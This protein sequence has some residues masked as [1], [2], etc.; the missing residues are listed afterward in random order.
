MKWTHFF[1]LVAIA[2]LLATPMSPFAVL[3]LFALWAK[4]LG[5]LLL[6]I[7][8]IFK[9]GVCSK[10]K[11]PLASFEKEES[12]SKNQEKPNVDLAQSLVIWEPL[13]FKV[14][15]SRNTP[16]TLTFTRTGNNMTATCTCPAGK[17]L[18]QCKHRVNLLYGD[19]TDLVSGQDQ[20]PSLHRMFTSTDIEIAFNRFAASEETGKGIQ[21]AKK[22]LARAFNDYILCKSNHDLPCKVQSV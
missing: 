17:N 4:W 8:E 16:Y 20:L 9:T 12:V 18:M 10:C 5:G 15:G 6:K 1:S 11:G 19:L 13:K 21:T 3:W 2:I 14:Q 7:A 22:E